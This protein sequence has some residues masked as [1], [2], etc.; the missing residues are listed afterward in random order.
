MVE[1]PDRVPRSR[2]LDPERSF[3]V[4]APAGSGKTELL[5]QRYLLLLARVERPEE[6]VA[7]TFTRKA[8]AEMRKRIFEALARARGEP[9][10]VEAHAARTWDLA[11]EALA[12]NDRLQWKLEENAARLRVQTIDALCV[13]LTRRMPI[14]SRL[15]AQP[16]TVDDATAHYEEAAHNLLSAVEI[17]DD[18]RHED[19]ALLLAHLDNDVENAVELIVDMLA[20]RDHW[21]RTLGHANDRADLE[22]AL[23]QV[24]LAAARKCREHYPAAPKDV[25]ALIAFAKGLLTLEG[26]W[27]QRE[28]LAQKLKENEPLREAL[29]EMLELPPPCYT[30][31]QWAALEAITRILPRAVAELRLVFAARNQCD[32]VEVAQ[33]A[34]RALR[35]A[36][37]PTDLMLALDYRIRHILVDEFQDTSHAQHELL[38]LLTEGWEAGDG[39]TLFVVGDPMQS[40]YRFRQAEV[41]LFLDAR[42]AGIGAIALEPLTLSANFRSQPAIVRWVNDAFRRILPMADDIPAGAVGYSESVAMPAADGPTVE[43]HP[44]FDKDAA[45]EASCVVDLVKRARAED[46]EGTIG[47][48]VRS[49]GRLEQIVRAL[50]A[51]GLRYRAVE[52]EPLAQCTVVQDLLAITL[53]L[54]HLGD[55]TAWLSLLRAPWCGLELADLLRLGKSG[56][57]WDAINDAGHLAAMSEDGR[58]RAERV[59][60]ILAPCVENR[61]RSSLR[62]AVESAWLALDGP[63]CIEGP[64]ELEDAHVYLDFLEANEDAGAIADRAAFELRL[65]KLYAVPDL[66][67]DERLQVM[68]MH[69]AKGLEFDTVI[70][71]GLGAGTESDRGRLF[72]WTKRREAAQANLLVA[73]VNATGSDDTLIYDYIRRLDRAHGEHETGRLLYVATTRARKRLHL[74]GD[75][76]RNRQGGLAPRKGSL[77][78]Q[79]WPVIEPRFVA[80][81]LPAVAREPRS[82]RAA[83][84]LRRVRLPVAPCAVPPGIAWKAP[85]ERANL[86]QEIEF[87]WAGQTARRVGTVAHRWLQR[88]ADEGLASWNRERVDSMEKVFRAN[89]V[90]AGVGEAELEAATRDVA[91]AIGNA[92]DDERGRWILGPHPEA[93]SEYRLTA[94]LDD[95][96]R[97]FI[98]D[99]YFVE[100]DGTRWIVDYKTGRH[101]GADREAFLDRERE[102]YR[103]QLAGYGRLFEGPSRQGLYFPLLP[104]WRDL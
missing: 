77:L 29:A 95:T 22:A 74:C 99:R 37:G 4:Q 20:S 79:L 87:S 90:A 38:T 96:R 58:A 56:T 97:N 23:V 9:R 14:V 27:R 46:A 104:G 34:V 65:K 32:F 70:L 91:R 92:L 89:L 83:Q 78:A 30:D 47:I 68:T 11:R 33:G 86:A 98:V 63:G 93:R 48:L 41:G 52:I 71:P 64:T 102:R 72:T 2:A 55:R 101:E 73:P 88:I 69:K 45:G 7:I 57:V 81:A 61:L 16:E 39:R 26:K 75:V 10:P 103:E 62:D 15:G 82:P 40:I 60:A 3:I 28:P 1:A 24:R 51:A 80:P 84:P 67:A 76:G 5:I 18:K 85:V 94:Q 49:R 100:A 44:F 12:A 6:I 53:A 35:D 25:D 8:A 31:E 13:S 17:P 59:R 42:R 43:V 66:Q 21:L 50:R 19:V 54:S 36:D